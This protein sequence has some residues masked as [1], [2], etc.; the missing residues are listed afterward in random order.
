MIFGKKKQEQP[1]LPISILTDQ[2]LI[3]GLDEDGSA[4]AAA[5]DADGGC[6]AI[7]DARV[8]PMNGI[9]IPARSFDRWLMPSFDK[10]IAIWSNDPAA[11][12]ILFGAW[13]DF[14]SPIKTLIYAG[15]FSIVCTLYS[16][17]ED[18]PP[19]FMLHSF[20][21]FEDGAITSLREKTPQALRARWGVLHS[22]LMHGFSVE[23]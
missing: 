23:K 14:Q 10:V 3:E 5:F 20:A 18:A 13:D 12:E 17:E 19:D 11:E 9:Q 16:D 2:F 8:Q 1:A 7:L 22:A 15:D 21:P 6:L 4:L